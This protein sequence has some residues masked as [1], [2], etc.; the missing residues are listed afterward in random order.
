[1]AGISSDFC[2]ESPPARQYYKKVIFASA[3]RRSF[4]VTLAAFDH[5]G[6]SQ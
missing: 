2:A 6:G 1:M 5:D 4:A 3:S